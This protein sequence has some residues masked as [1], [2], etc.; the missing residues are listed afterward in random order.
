MSE[1]TATKQCLDCGL[2][3]IENFYQKRDGL[4]SYCKPCL[5]RRNVV[6]QEKRRDERRAMGIPVSLDFKPDTSYLERHLRKREVEATKCL[7]ESSPD[8]C[9]GVVCFGEQGSY[10][11]MTDHFLRGGSEMRTTPRYRIY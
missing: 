9:H 8:E 5:K 11:G 1:T 2:Q 7:S 6:N 10:R 4:C 3:P